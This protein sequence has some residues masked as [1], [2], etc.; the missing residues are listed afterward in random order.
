[1]NIQ[2]LL[3]EKLSKEQEERKHEP[4]GCIT[5]S[6]LGQCF[7]RQLYK[8]RGEP[9][10]N[11]PDER[12]LRIFKMGHSVHQTIYDMVRTT[13]EPKQAVKDILMSGL[14]NEH[15]DKIVDKILDVIKNPPSINPNIQIEVEVKVDDILGYADIVTDEMVID[16]KSVHSRKFWYMGRKKDEDEDA[17]VERFRTDQKDN[18]LQVMCYCY[19]LDRPMGSLVYVSRDDWCINQYKFELKDWTTEV[20]DELFILR[21]FWENGETPRA[22]PRLYKQKDGKYKECSYCQFLDTCTKKEND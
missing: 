4:S 5:P 16:I 20:T 11:P 19:M 17:A 21:K 2:Q 13:K 12:G 22:V 15:I 1:M 8:R 6:S 7:R 18:I 9:V 14:A 10:S 3:N